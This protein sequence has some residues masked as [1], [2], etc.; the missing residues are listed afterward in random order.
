[1]SEGLVDWIK[2]KVNAGTEVVKKGL[3][4]IWNFLS[5]SAKVVWDSIVEDIFKPG[6]EALKNVAT[7]LFGP[8]VVA[9][10]ETTAK[11]VLN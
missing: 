9:A 7:K 3:S 5:S 6:L 2:D 4:K 11:K 8:E 10:I 1:M